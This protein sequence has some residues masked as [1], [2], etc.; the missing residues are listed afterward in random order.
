[1]KAM[2]LI[3]TACLM[4]YVVPELKT[5]YDN[6]MTTF[7]VGTGQSDFVMAVLGI[8]P[9]LMM[10]ILIFGTIFKLFQMRKPNIMP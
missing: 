7:V 1:M 5:I 9:L 8:G 10:G 4:M 6:L 2:V 3:A